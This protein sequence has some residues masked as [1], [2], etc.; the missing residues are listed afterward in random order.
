MDQEN[1]ATSDRNRNVL[2]SAY[3]SEY[4]YGMSSEVVMGIA[5]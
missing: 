5:M 4:V 3:L 2:K 1:N